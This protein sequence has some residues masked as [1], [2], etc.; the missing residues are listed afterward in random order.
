M[1]PKAAFWRPPDSDYWVASWSSVLFAG[2]VFEAIPFVTSPTAIYISEEQDPAQHF[3]GE[4]EFGYG[5]LISP[6]CDMYGSVDPEEMSHP[7]RVLV[8]VLPVSEVVEHTR[9]GEESENLLRMRDALHAYMYLPSLS[10]HFPESVACLYRPTVVAESFLADP[11]RRVAQ[12]GAEARRHLKVK[13]AAYWARAKVS[14][15]QLPLAERDEG[16]ARSS[17]DPPSRYDRPNAFRP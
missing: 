14:H 15:D 13:L 4:I 16:E 9:K 3:V 2:D 11:P 7:F 12:M 1:G 8:P 5:L 10:D 6:T 17:V